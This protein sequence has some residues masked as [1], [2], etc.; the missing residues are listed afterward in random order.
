MDL[1]DA[2]ADL[3]HGADLTHGDAG[4][5]VFNLLPRKGTKRTKGQEIIFELFGPFCSNQ[6]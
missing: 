2:V 5:K 1:S 6:S 4:F 3:D